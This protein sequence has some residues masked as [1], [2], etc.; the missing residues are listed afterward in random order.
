MYC[1]EHRFPSSGTNDSDTPSSDSFDSRDHEATSASSE[2]NSER[3]LPPCGKESNNLE[4]TFTVSSGDDAVCSEPE[5]GVRGRVTTS[6][7]LGVD[8]EVSKSDKL[9]SETVYYCPFTASIFLNLRTAPTRH[10][11]K[12]IIVISYTLVR[13]KSEVAFGKLYNM[14]SLL[15]SLSTYHLVTNRICTCKVQD[16]S[17][18]EERPPQAFA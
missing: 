11:G 17:A 13:T 1:A 5:P 4:D 10:R 15:S 9:H 8:H 2:S 16:W 18:T 12:I 14:L 6:N 7:N 3:H